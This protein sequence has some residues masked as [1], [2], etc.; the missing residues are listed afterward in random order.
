ME[1][2]TTFL[3]DAGGSH[4]WVIVSDPRQDPDHILIVSLTTWTDCKD[5]TCIVE[6]GEHPWATHRTCVFYRKAMIVT[7]AEIHDGKDTGRL[8]VQDPMPPDLLQRIWTGA[9]Q[10]DFLSGAA[11]RLLQQQGFI[12]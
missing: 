5:S 10:S 11:K 8:K 4:L 2:G 3:P 7:L 12:K 6:R 1:V 9:A